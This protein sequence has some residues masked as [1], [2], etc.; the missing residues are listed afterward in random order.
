MVAEL[1]FV[2]SVEHARRKGSMLVWIGPE[3]ADYISGLLGLEPGT[4]AELKPHVAMAMDEKEAMAYKDCV[5]VCYHG[6]TSKY[7]AHIMNERH[8]IRS[9]SMKGGVAAVVGE[10]F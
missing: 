2:E 1:D 8:G 5:F 4:M 3:P 7:L 6:R 9:V 10:I